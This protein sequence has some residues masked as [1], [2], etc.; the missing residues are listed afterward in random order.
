[1]SRELRQQGHKVDARE[2]HRGADP[3]TPLQSGPGVT[4]G[5]FGLIGFLDRALGPLEVTLPP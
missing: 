3:K 4:R 5:K 1:L 2:D